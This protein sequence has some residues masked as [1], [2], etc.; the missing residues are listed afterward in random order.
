MMNSE[1]RALVYT[2]AI[3]LVVIVLVLI[4]TYFVY[5]KGSGYIFYSE[6]G[7]DKIMHVQSYLPVNSHSARIVTDDGDTKYIQ[8]VYE[9]YSDEY[10]KDDN[11][12]NE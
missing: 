4:F 8:F 9:Y 6:R 12:D 5:Y 10:I 2:M 11:D 3:F 1:I 7:V